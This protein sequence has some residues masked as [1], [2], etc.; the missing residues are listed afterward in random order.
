M[1]KKQKPGVLVTRRAKE[2]DLQK[3]V[4]G[5]AIGTIP[6]NNTQRAC[7]A[8]NLCCKTF[9]IDEL[10]KPAGQLC[11][12]WKP[13]CRCSIYQTRPPTYRN[14]FCA[15][16]LELVGDEFRPTECHMVLTHNVSSGQLLVA[17]DPDYP[18]AWMRP[19]Y[20]SFFFK[21]SLKHAPV[22]IMVGDGEHMFELYPDRCIHFKRVELTGLDAFGYCKI[23]EARVKAEIVEGGD[24]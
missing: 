17:V 16:L 13:D 18:N 5:R 15:W 24:K 2:H 22:R 20:L 6:S 1:A 21:H 9:P 10:N 3:S 4:A 8:C 11:S 23:R 14:Y 12:P 19:K 7:G